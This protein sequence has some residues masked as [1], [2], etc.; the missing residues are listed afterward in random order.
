MAEDERLREALLELQLLR[1]REAQ[2]LDETRKLVE[3]LE[4]YSSAA[5]PGA[6]LSSI[7]IS[8]RNTIGA[9]VSL[10][11]QIDKTGAFTVLA[12][13]ARALTGQCLVPPFDLSARSRN[14]ADLTMLGPWDGEFDASRYS[15][16]QAVPV[17]ADGAPHAVLVFKVDKPPFEKNSLR[18]VER[19]AGLAMR[20]WQG[21]KIAGENKLLAAAIHGSSSGFA[22]ADATSD[23][24]PLI[25]SNR[26]LGPVGAIIWA[27]ISSSRSKVLKKRVS[28]ATS[29]FKDLIGCRPKADAIMESF[30]QAIRSVNAE[31][32]PAKLYWTFTM[33]F[34]TK[35]FKVLLE[36]K[37]RSLCSLETE[38][39]EDCEAVETAEDL[40][41]YV[42]GA[43]LAAVWHATVRNIASPVWA[44]LSQLLNHL[45]TTDSATSGLTQAQLSW[46]QKRSN[47]GLAM[48][49]GP[50][51]VVF[52]NLL[53][54]L[55]KATPTRLGEESLWSDLTLYCQEQLVSL[56]S[57]HQFNFRSD[58]PI[59]ALA[60]V[61][62]KVLRK[63]YL[64]ASARS[65]TGDL[66]AREAS[67]RPRGKGSDAG[68]S[69]GG[70]SFRQ[71][72]RRREDDAARQDDHSL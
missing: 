14:I 31:C 51:L 29:N 48:P 45:M 23:E 15:A 28:K 34:C 43:V 71:S 62:I 70:V 25:Y 61:S 46:L 69:S 17:M 52:K 40:L 24:R 6:A 42:S 33:E 1:T 5:T 8:L 4:A 47:G 39:D 72:Q 20:A 41:V 32:I 19:L 44:D 65:L 58:A 7:F 11:G 55:D 66:A 12:S 56:L 49:K 21:S 13:D 36:E 67:K 63:I 59:Q 9:D 30:I 27:C 10:L 68:E 37:A 50:A 26:I 60:Y 53:N 18:L 3:C 16:L 57:H 2:S 38:L 35:L 54:K 22:M 64:K